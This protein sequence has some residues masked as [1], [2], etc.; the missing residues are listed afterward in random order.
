M[1]NIDNNQAEDILWIMITSNTFCL[2]RSELC[3]PINWD[4][5][6]IDKQ[7]VLNC[8]VPILEFGV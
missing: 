2:W 8:D 1:G 3:K 4:K 7:K 5:S 6:I